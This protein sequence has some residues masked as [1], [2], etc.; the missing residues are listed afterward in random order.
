ML[1]L[2]VERLANRSERISQS[3]STENSEKSFPLHRLEENYELFKRVI[4]ILNDLDALRALSHTSHFWRSKVFIEKDRYHFGFVSEASL[5]LSAII[6]KSI[7]NSEQ[8]P[9]YLQTY[10]KL[11]GF[12]DKFGVTIHFSTFV[13]HYRLSG[14]QELPLFESM[15]GLRSL[16][17]SNI[18]EIED[19]QLELVVTVFKELT[20][21]DLGS[22]V[23]ISQKGVKILAQLTTLQKLNISAT[24]IKDVT[25]LSALTRLRALDCSFCHN[26]QVASLWPL[27]RLT[28]LR[29]INNLNSGEEGWG[30]F[31]ALTGLRS[32]ELSMVSGDKVLSSV[33]FLTHLER[34]R[35]SSSDIT[36]IGLG[37]LQGLMRLRHLDLTRCV[38]ITT[39]G[40]TNIQH[41]PA[42]ERLNLSMCDKIVGEGLCCL[43][44]LTSLRELDVSY[45]KV[46]LADSDLSGLTHLKGL[47][48][49]R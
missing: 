17:M 27:T 43:A 22:C 18:Q 40:L 42:L 48:I 35:V 37:C 19:Q 46:P 1:G 33:K 20:S 6:Q 30:V 14:I 9:L 16:D 45:L 34:L 7:F 29:L 39:A 11:R 47:H 15:R 36:D 41:L 8:N 12:Q 49:K 32:L 5:F 4:L 28:Q 24:R 38:E 2:A 21:L 10:R 26:F 25:E 13:H 3:S 31:T 44:T 23:C